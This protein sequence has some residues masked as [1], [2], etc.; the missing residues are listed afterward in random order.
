[1]PQWVSDVHNSY[2]GDKWIKEIQKKVNQQ[3]DDQSSNPYSQHQQLMWY[4]G[5][6][7]IGNTGN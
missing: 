7:Y 1:M 2:L 4:K 3:P 6:I 5:R